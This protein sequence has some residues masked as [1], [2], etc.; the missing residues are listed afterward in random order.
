[1]T[2]IGGRSENFLITLCK[3]DLNNLII[4][5][6]EM[7]SLDN[8]NV[9][10]SPIQK[11]TCFF[12]HG[13]LQHVLWP[14]RLIRENAM[15]QLHLWHCKLLLRFID[16][17]LYNACYF[18]IIFISTF[19]PSTSIQKLNK[20]VSLLLNRRS[21]WYYILLKI[22]L[23]PPLPTLLFLIDSLGVS[24]SLS[25]SHKRHLFTIHIHTTFYIRYYLQSSHKK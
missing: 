14:F 8:A 1:M 23:C 15:K 19:T 11:Y 10:R 13:A 7:E 6:A 9:S 2:T 20:I 3:I 17:P 12:I 21:F 5:L 18:L 25:S 24:H 22:I 4:F 16:Q